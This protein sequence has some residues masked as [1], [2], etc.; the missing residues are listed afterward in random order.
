MQVMIE[1]WGQVQISCVDSWLWVSHDEAFR[2]SS[3]V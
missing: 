2:G 3:G 1:L